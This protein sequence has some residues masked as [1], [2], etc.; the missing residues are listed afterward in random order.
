MCD[1]Q[2]C[3]YLLPLPSSSSVTV[4]KMNFTFVA[5]LEGALP[6]TLDFTVGKDYSKKA[7]SQTFLS[8]IKMRKLWP[9]DLNYCLEVALGCRSFFKGLLQ[10]SI[11][12]SGWSNFVFNFKTL[13]ISPLIRD[14]AFSKDF[15]TCHVEMPGE[16]CAKEK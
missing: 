6:L 7:L 1:E 13:P 2:S 16:D 10:H 3:C 8:L 15:R 14:T 11:S 9:P 4:I 12:S 5:I